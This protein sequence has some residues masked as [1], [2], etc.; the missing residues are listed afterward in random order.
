[1]SKKTLSRLLA[2][3]I[4]FAAIIANTA[5]AK[6]EAWPKEVGLGYQKY[7]SLTILKSTGDLEKRLKEKGVA[8]KWA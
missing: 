4:V 7:G 3:T 8:V 1:M 2:M 6:G 5:F